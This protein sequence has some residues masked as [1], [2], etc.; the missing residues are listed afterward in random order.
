[1]FRSMTYLSWAA[2]CALALLTSPARATILTFEV[3][4]R[5]FDGEPYNFPDVQPY[6]PG[7]GYPEG[8]Q[9]PFDYGSNVSS[10]E[11]TFH[12][13][14]IDGSLVTKIYRYGNG[15]EGFTPNVAVYYGP[16]SIFTGGP[17]LW[18][19][20]FGDLDGVLYQGS[21]HGDPPIGND[22]D[23][24]DIVLVAEAGFDVQLYGFDL[25]AGLNIGDTRTIN[26]IVI[27]DG[28]PFPFLTPDNFLID[29]IPGVEVPGEGRLSVGF[30][31]PLQSSVIWIRID[32]SNLGP[33]SQL[34][35]IDNIRFG[36][37]ESDNPSTLDPAT[38]D[39]AFQ[40]SEQVVP[41]P[42]SLALWL[43]GGG[44]AAMS[45]LGTRKRRG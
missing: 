15:G 35:G 36:Q 8:F 24:L 25:A 23:F 20:G 29:P 37:V 3:F 5:G 33:D 27:F 17:S 44:F 4:D 28:V 31:D 21:E 10:L 22:Y 45:R 2:F 40:S 16:Y 30:S 11:T 32:A 12:D 41:E 13:D 19:E 42:V 38:I 6:E 43:V 9:V 34:I 26:S 7:F 18:R 1:M 39:A 14:P